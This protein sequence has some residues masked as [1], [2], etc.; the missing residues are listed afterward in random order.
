MLNWSAMK[1]K[2]L[3]RFLGGRYFATRTAKIRFASQEI[4]FWRIAKRASDVKTRTRLRQ[5]EMMD[6]FEDFFKSKSRCS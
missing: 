4:K 6:D 5:T 2:I 3:I 1:K